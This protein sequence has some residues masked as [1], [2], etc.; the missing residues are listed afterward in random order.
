MFRSEADR[1]CDA[2]SLSIQ[3]TGEVLMICLNEKLNTISLSIAFIFVSNSV[4]G[5]DVTSIAT[6][7][8][9]TERKGRVMRYQKNRYEGKA[10]GNRCNQ[11]RIKEMRRDR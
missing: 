11:N 10:I 4:K 9:I 2:K 6:H 3:R 7:K 8:K 1:N 5:G